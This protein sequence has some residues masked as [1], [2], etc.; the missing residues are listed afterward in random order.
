MKENNIERIN[1]EKDF[2][3]IFNYL[4]Q[5]ESKLIT[6]QDKGEHWSNLRS[7]EYLSEF[8]KPKIIYPNMTKFFPFVYDEESYYTNQKC[9]IIT[10]EDLKYLT[11]IFNS[12]LFFF[13][14]KDNF[15][16]LL[17]ETREL[18]KV[19]FE[20]IP[21]KKNRDNFIIMLL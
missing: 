14:F 20:K 3:D 5:F 21:V 11:A 6:R 2:P 10:G 17:G 13:C 15:P 18:S 7:C 9:F 8:E 4:K 16:E 19:F 12:K 1:A